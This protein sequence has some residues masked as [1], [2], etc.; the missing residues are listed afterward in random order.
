MNNKNVVYFYCTLA[1]EIAGERKYICRDHMNPYYKWKMA[2]TF[3]TG[4]PTRLLARL[5]RQE[6]R[7]KSTVHREYYGKII[8]IREHHET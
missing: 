5:A 1:K 6:Y 8:I 7:Q 4:F 3:Y 2:S